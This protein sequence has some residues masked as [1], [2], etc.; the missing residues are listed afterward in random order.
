MLHPLLNICDR[1][2]GVLLVPLSVE[3]LGDRPE[4]D[5]EVAGQILWLDLTPFLA[6]EPDEA[7][8][9]VAHDDPGVRT[10]DK[11]AA[12]SLRLYPHVLFHDFLPVERSGR[13]PHGGMCVRYNI[14]H[15]ILI[16]SRPQWRLF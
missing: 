10:R 12:I 15:M 11:R 16:M 5:Y 3:S 4:L 8:F 6:P 2:A 1:V 13:L 7:K 9:I 14:Y